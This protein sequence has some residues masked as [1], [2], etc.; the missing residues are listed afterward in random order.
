[1]DSDGVV[2]MDSLADCGDEFSECF[3]PIGISEVNFEFVI[4]RFLIAILPGTGFAAH[5]EGNAEVL[6]KGDIV[7]RSIFASLIGMQD[8]WCRMRIYRRDQGCH[9]QLHAVRREDTEPDDFSGEQIDDRCQIHGLA[10]KRNMGE[11]GSPDVVRILWKFSEQEARERLSI[12]FA[13]PEF[14]ASPAVRLDAKFFHHSPDSLLVDPQEN[15]NASVPI[16]RML[17]QH[18]LNPLFQPPI[19]FWEFMPVIQALPGYPD[20]TGICCCG[21]LSLFVQPFFCATF[22]S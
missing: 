3:K 4:E 21:N 15:R 12:R 7:F 6:R 5:G 16:A 22:I 14:L 20:R 8:H 2:G 1:M 19:F 17:I 9:H 10:M 18:L 11:V 13:F